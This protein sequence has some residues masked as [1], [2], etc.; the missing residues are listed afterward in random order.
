M[1]RERQ[2]ALE[3]KVVIQGGDYG[4]FVASAMAQIEER[5][6][7]NLLHGIHLNMATILL[8]PLK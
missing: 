6:K 1:K 3:E 7:K 4:S 5:E 8:P 2:I